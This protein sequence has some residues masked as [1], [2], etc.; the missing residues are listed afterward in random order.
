MTKKNNDKKLS[1]AQK[2]TNDNK[3][4]SHIIDDKK[5]LVQIPKNETEGKLSSILTI[6]IMFALREMGID[7]VDITIKE[8]KD[9]FEII[10]EK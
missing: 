9:M 4:T 8:K 3:Y 5:V 6:G 2:T 7:N 1:K 10:V